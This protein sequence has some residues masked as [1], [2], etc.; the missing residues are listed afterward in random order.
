MY[1]AGLAL[2]IFAAGHFVPLD[3]NK[4]DTGG[5]LTCLTCFQENKQVNVLPQPANANP[6]LNA[7]PFSS[8]ELEMSFQLQNV[9]GD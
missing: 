2:R 7:S 3:L 6:A 5:N 4:Q 8:F 1:D 9:Q